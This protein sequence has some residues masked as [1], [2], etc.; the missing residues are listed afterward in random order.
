MEVNA[1]VLQAWGYDD[2][3]AAVHTVG[4]GLINHTYLLTDMLQNKKFILQHINQAVF[5]QPQIIADNVKIVA[6][7]LRN[8]A[9]DYFMVT[10]IPTLSGFEMA[11]IEGE[12]WRLTPFVENAIAFDVLS[13]PKQAYEAAKQFGKFTRLLQHCPINE[14]KPTI[15]GFHDLALRMTQFDEA[16]DQAAPAT[17]DAAHECI[18]AALKH[19]HILKYFQSFEHSK[20][21][22][23]RVIHHDTKISNVLLNETT[24][25]GI[26]VI[27]LDTL[28]TGKFISDLGDM[29][30]TYLCAFSEN[31]PDLSKINIRIDYFEAMIQG[32]LSEMKSILTPTE[33]DLI[34]FSGKYMMYMQALRF[35]T[36]FLN[37]NIYYPIHYP[38]QNLDRAANQFKLLAELYAHEKVLQGIIEKY[39]K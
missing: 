38:T 20:N 3:N 21:F 5:K 10:P 27:D 30:R 11:E 25:E 23:S 31:E 14:M 32:Y 13:E 17:K 29:M 1:A 6:D 34:L 7:Y 35:L 36:D 12:F 16:L 15:P 39:L 24:F 2:T 4:S 19:T 9:P 37:E 28:M 33:K 18:Q 26:C 22:P 8:T